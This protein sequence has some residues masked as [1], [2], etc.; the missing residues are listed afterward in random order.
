LD[1]S[2]RNDCK[3]YG[4]QL[5]AF[6]KEL[7]GYKSKEETLVASCEASRNEEKIVIEDL[8][9]GRNELGV[10]AE[11]PGVYTGELENLVEGFD[12]FI[13]YILRVCCLLLQLHSL[14][15]LL[16]SLEVISLVICFNFIS[17]FIHAQGVNSLVLLFLCFEVSIISIMLSLIVAFVKGTGSDYVRVS[18]IMRAL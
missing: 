18:V 13:L 11:S 8:G 17:S 4:E 6:I 9:V 14:F 10:F 5:K 7:K 1:A 3:V 12:F 15:R 2:L 16:L